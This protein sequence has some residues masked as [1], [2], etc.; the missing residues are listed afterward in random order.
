[1]LWILIA[2]LAGIAWAIWFILQLDLWIPLLATGVLGLIA[3][4]LFLNQMIR[5]RRS[6]MALE[7]AIAEQGDLQ[8]RNARPEKRAE[9][10]AL[11]KQIID[12]IGAIKRSKLGGK[13]R[14]GGALYSLPWYAIIGPP[15]AGK[16]TALKHSGMVF[17]YADTSIRGVGGTRNCDWWFTNEAILLDTAA[18]SRSTGSSWPWPCP[19]SSTRPS[20]RS[21]A[22]ARSCGRASTR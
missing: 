20:S 7:R 2:L 10:Q 12:G 5:S 1:V 8:A 3:L 22:W 21:R 15:G 18:T 9:I 4:G 14:G 13:K 11:Q 19:T 17:P 6:A 16:T